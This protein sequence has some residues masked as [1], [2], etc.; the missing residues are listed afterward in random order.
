MSMKNFDKEKL[1]K[2][3]IALVLTV[4]F[5]L[6]LPLF[7]GISYLWENQMDLNKLPYSFWHG[8]DP[9]KEMYV[10]F[11]T[12]KP[13]KSSIVYWSTD[14]LV[15]TTMTIDEPVSFHKYHLKSL[16]ANT[17]YYYQTYITGEDGTKFHWGKIGKFKTSSGSFEPFNFTTYGDSQRFL[18][19]GHFQRLADAFGS[20]DFDTNFLFVAGDVCQE[21]YNQATWNHYFKSAQSFSNKF[22]LIT[23]PG[24]HDSNKNDS[25]YAKY[26]GITE[27]PDKFYFSFN[28]SNIQFIGMQISASGEWNINDPKVVENFEW[29]KQTLANGQDKMFRIMVFH[30][31]MVVSN[32]RESRAVDTMIPILSEYN[33][34]LVI[35]GHYHHYERLLIGDTTVLCVAGGGGFQDFALEPQPE[36]QVIRVVPHFTQI[37]QEKPDELIIKSQMPNGPVF[38]QFKLTAKDG[39]AIQTPMEV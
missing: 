17:V 26:F 11:E 4:V 5:I 36:T 27:S 6:P 38:D 9:Q 35:H 12:E 28:Y 19:T 24:N 16:T 15:N 2:V 10:A 23:V 30:R 20:P 33:V 21:E 37:I 7:F 34:S 14:I 32:H 39:K 8:I 1:R 25:L 29:L 31:D 3:L 18:G 22:P 13:Y